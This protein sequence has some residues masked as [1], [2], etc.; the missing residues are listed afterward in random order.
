MNTTQLECFVQVADNLSFRRAADELHLSQPTVSKQIASLE[1]ELGGTL[2]VR[3]TREVALTALGATFLGDARE[4][5]RLTYAAGER[6]RRQAEGTGLAIGY[7]DSNELMRLEP[8]LDALRREYDA[9][10]SLVQGSRDANVV[11]LRR[12]QVDVVLG[13]ETSSPAEAGIR[14]KAL[15]KDTLSC[16]VRVDS[17][18]AALDEAGP[19]DVAGIPQVLVQSTGLRRRGYRA[20]AALPA[21]EADLVTTCATSSEAYCLVDA[22]FGYALVPTLYTMPDPFHKILRWRIA[23]GATYGLYH[24][25]GKR[26]GI[27]PRFVELAA[28]TYSQEGY[29]RPAPESWAPST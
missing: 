14:F 21:V 4:I 28:A 10:V 11:R 18:L 13:F 19:E 20:Q 22:G 17:P 15:R 9:H 16:V 6:A 23:A 8:V 7:S 26:K 25:I 1:D 3:N 5:L 2:F 29:D 12:E 27:V 24:R